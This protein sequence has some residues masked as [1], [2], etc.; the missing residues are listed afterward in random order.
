VSFDGII[1]RPPFDD[2]L[3]I[4]TSPKFKL[5]GHQ[6]GYR[7]K[8]NAYDAWTP[9]IFEQYLR[10]M[11]T[12][13][14]NAVELIPPRSDDDDSPHFHLSKIDMMAEMSRIC[15]EYGIEVRL[16]VPHIMPGDRRHRR[17]FS[18]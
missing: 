8:V 5:R 14:I 9:A 15:D 4:T 10:D 12:F 2:H 16:I 6:I 13:G 11:I 3:D 7:P 17:S 1:C 18:T